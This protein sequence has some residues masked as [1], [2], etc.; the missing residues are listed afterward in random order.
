[1][2]ISFII[3][4]LAVIGGVGYLATLATEDRMQICASILGQAQCLSWF[5]NN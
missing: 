2:K 3:V 1:M 4:F 5:G